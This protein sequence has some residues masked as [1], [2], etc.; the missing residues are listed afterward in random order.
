[1]LEV[2][3]QVDRTDKLL[4]RVSI[5]FRHSTSTFKHERDEPFNV[6]NTGRDNL[7]P[8]LN[9]GCGQ[10]N[11]APRAGFQWMA[12]A[13]SPFEVDPGV[14]ISS[15]VSSQTDQ[16]KILFLSEMSCAC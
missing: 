6:F 7:K 5:R 9:T 12:D 10:F 13:A 11:T 8:S 15:R 1:M 16:V 2:E 14:C 3:A 4:F